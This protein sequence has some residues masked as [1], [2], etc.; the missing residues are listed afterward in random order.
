MVQRKRVKKQKPG[1][2]PESA[3][4]PAEEPDP[5]GGRRVRREPVRNGWKV[6]C[7]FCGGKELAINPD[8]DKAERESQEI[9]DRHVEKCVPRVEPQ[10]D[11]GPD[12]QQER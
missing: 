5:Y 2:E 1:P 12:P 8:R 11:Q 10:P 7:D 6:E 4:T 9:V 3:V